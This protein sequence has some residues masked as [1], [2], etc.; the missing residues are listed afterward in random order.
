MTKQI[1]G[2]WCLSVFAALLVVGLAFSIASMSEVGAQEKT[3]CKFGVFK[4]VKMNGKIVEI[5][6]HLW[7]QNHIYRVP[8]TPIGPVPPECL[9]CPVIIT[10]NPE[11]IEKMGLKDIMT[12]VEGPDFDNVTLR[13]PHDLDSFRNSSIGQGMMQGP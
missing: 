12:I 1:T 10:F 13:I 7:L 5:C 11:I 6:N 3:P 9:S 8:I 4:I 2:I